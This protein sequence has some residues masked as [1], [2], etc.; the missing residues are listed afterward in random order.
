MISFLF[1]NKS[2]Y[3]FVHQHGMQYQMMTFFFFFLLNIYRHTIL[4]AE[5]LVYLLF[6]LMGG[7]AG[8]VVFITA[9]HT[10][11]PQFKACYHQKILCKKGKQ[12]PAK[13]NQIFSNDSSEWHC[14]LW[15]PSVPWCVQKLT[16]R[17][18]NAIKWI[19]EFNMAYVDK[20]N[21]LGD[22]KI[23]H[24]LFAFFVCGLCLIYTKTFLL[25]DFMKFIDTKTIYVHF[26]FLFTHSSFN[27][28]CSVEKVALSN[29]LCVFLFRWKIVIPRV[30]DR[31][32]LS[33]LFPEQW[34]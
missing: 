6:C 3:I 7:V 23:K 1:Q 26:F 21:T 15:I 2:N 34:N 5:L 24:F 14:K 33:M 16:S 10:G 18:I 8:L 4:K 13:G 28:N 31:K 9:C 20:R 29:L 12:I 25:L 27:Y 32:V 19:I 11:G 17:G 30:N 22:A